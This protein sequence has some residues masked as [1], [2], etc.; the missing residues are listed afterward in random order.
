MGQQQLLLIILGVIV[1]GIAVAV[2]ITLFK[3]NAVSSNRDA[4]TNDLVNIASHAQQYFRRPL[5]LGGG[6]GDFS[7]LTADAAGLKRLTSMTGGVNANGTYKILTAGT[8]GPGGKVVL[9]GLGTET[10]ND[11][12]SPVKVVMNVWADSA[13]VDNTQTN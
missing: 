1:V 5:A 2:G 6:A 11:G 7:S 12:S 10:G 4:V 9:Q 8:S 3:D 13:K